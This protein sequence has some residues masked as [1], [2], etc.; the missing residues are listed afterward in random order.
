MATAWSA[1]ELPASIRS[2]RNAP[3]KALLRQAEVVAGGL[4]RRASS[5]A[6]KAVESRATRIATLIASL[7]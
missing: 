3:S 2:C 6:N 5:D 7:A 1:S 4:R